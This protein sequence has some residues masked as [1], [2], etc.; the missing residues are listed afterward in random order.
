MSKEW[1]TKNVKDIK[2]CYEINP[3]SGKREMSIKTLTIIEW[4]CLSIGIPCITKDNTQSVYNRIFDLEELFGQIVRWEEGKTNVLGKTE[5]APVYYPIQIEDI[6]KLVGLET[7]GPNISDEEWN[8]KVS[9]IRHEAEEKTKKIENDF[10]EA[11]KSITEID[12][13]KVS[14]V[15]PNMYNIPENS[16]NPM[17]AIPNPNKT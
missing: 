3:I 11:G 5:W 9:D 2:Q 8:K 15:I 17:H 14:V 7:N 10:P 4:L 12:M 13:R 16:N 6:E 1:S